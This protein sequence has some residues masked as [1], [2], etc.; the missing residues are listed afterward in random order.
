MTAD[1]LRVITPRDVL[2]G[3]RVARKRKERVRQ[4]LRAAAEVLAERGF[5]ATNLDDVAERLDLTKATLYHY[6]PSKQA[7]ISACIEQLGSEVTERLETLAVTLNGTPRQRMRVLLREQATVLLQD[8]PET[9]RLFLRPGPWPEPHNAQIKKLRTRH[10]DV[11]RRTIEDG[12]RVGEF[13]ITDLDI[14]LHCIHGALDNVPRWYK[15]GSQAKL[16][17]TVERLVDTVMMLC[18]VLPE[19]TT[20]P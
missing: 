15:P 1:N 12:V 8:Y 14:A 11:F 3:D 7:L 9:A 17:K 16:R 13:R 18:G 20:R 10:N 4:I 2:A 6:F 5:H 19:E